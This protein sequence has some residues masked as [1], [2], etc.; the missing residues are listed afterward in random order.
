MEKSIKLTHDILDLN[1]HGR[2]SLGKVGVQKGIT[3]TC[4]IK[5]RGGGKRAHSSREQPVSEKDLRFNITNTIGQLETNTETPFIAIIVSKVKELMETINENPKKSATKLISKLGKKQLSTIITDTMNHSTRVSSRAQF[6]AE[7]VFDD[8]FK[9]IN[10]I[11]NF[12]E[13]TQ[14]L[15]SNVVLVTI[16]C[17]YSDP[18]GIIAWSA[19]TRAAAQKLSEA[20]VPENGSNCSVS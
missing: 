18:N 5:G 17:E 9:T 2:K 3:I 11:K 16:V 10:N 13:M 14:N 8:E 12:C 15:L 6:V 20:D 7:N 1:R 4:S 19:L